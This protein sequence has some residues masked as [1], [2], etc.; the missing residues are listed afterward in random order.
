MIERN[1][2][3]LKGARSALFDADVAFLASMSISTLVIGVDGA[4][5]API[6]REVVLKTK[7]FVAEGPIQ[8]AE[9]RKSHV[10][11]WWSRVVEGQ[12]DARWCL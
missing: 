10:R 9:L 4:V 2:R 6:A 12:W 7:D 5:V 3:E 8:V 1:V 11:H